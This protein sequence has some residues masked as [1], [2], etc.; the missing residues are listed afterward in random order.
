MKDTNEKQHQVEAKRKELNNKT[1]DRYG[2]ETGKP[3]DK[4]KFRGAGKRTTIECP[5]RAGTS[6]RFSAVV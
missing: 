2:E 4:F 6:A 1:D 5:P 3:V